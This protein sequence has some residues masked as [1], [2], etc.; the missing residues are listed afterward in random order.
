RDF[1]VTGVQTCALPIWFWA[2]WLARA[3]FPQG[4]SPELE[5]AYARSLLT[6]KLLTHEESGA[7]LAAA[8]ASFPAV[9][10]GTDNWD[11]R[12]CWLRDGY[13]SARTYDEIGRASCRGRAWICA[14]SGCV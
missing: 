14:G 12:Y 10:G 6:L 5:E 7:I 2:D 11:Y 9:P 13:Y 3:R 1:H 4:V 8:T